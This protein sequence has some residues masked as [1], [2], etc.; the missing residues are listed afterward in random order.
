MAVS[1]NLAAA[2]CSPSSYPTC[3][4]QMFARFSAQIKASCQRDLSAADLKHNTSLTAGTLLFGT[5]TRKQHLNSPRP[6][7]VNDTVGTHDPEL[8]TPFHTM[9]PGNLL[10]FSKTLELT[11]WVTSSV[12]ANSTSLFVATESCIKRSLIDFLFSWSN[13]V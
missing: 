7:L 6:F 12:Y 3:F 13:R 8:P 10:V 1:T 2:C 9:S 4:L 5:S 11:D